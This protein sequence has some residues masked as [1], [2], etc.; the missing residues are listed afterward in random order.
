[1][2]EATVLP[3]LQ[4][5]ILEGLRIHLPASASNFKL[6]PPSG[7]I[8]DGRFVPSGT[9]IGPL[10][11]MPPRLKEVFGEDAEVFRPERWLETTQE[12]AMEMRKVVDLAFGSG[13]YSCAG[14]TVAFVELNKVFVELLRQFDFQVVYPQKPWESVN[15]AVFLQKKMWVSVL[16]WKQAKR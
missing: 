7:D 3:Y 2:A 10:T 1:M 12:K 13:R 16:L 6:V 4:A 8:I 15:Y 5:V 9:K 11:E 14:K